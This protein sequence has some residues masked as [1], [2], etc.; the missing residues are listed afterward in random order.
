M[1]WGLSGWPA[2]ASR[3]PSCLTVWNSPPAR[4]AVRTH[5]R[6][7]D[8]AA[9]AGSRT[10]SS[11]AAGPRPRTTAEPP[12]RLG[13]GTGP[14]GGGGSGCRRS[15]QRSAS[16]QLKGRFLPSDPTRLLQVVA[17]H[18]R[19]SAVLRR[20]SRAS[21]KAA[22]SWTEHRA[23]RSRRRHRTTGT[24]YCASAGRQRPASR[25]R[26]A[27]SRVDRRWRRRGPPSLFTTQGGSIPRR[28]SS[29]QPRPKK[30]TSRRLPPSLHHFESEVGRAGCLDRA[31]PP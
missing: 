28:S 4:R 23:G 14:G 3:S 7:F 16:P 2:W 17:D 29:R 5:W 10:R 25:I 19:L 27:T 22:I 6:D 26:P 11:S 13:P 15:P 18:K 21:V 9:A 1:V 12:G 31:C 8:S 30:A 24:C 20:R